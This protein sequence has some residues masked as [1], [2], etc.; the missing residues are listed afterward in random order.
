MPAV[1]AV[2]GQVGRRMA[3]VAVAWLR[4]QTLVNPD[5]RSAEGISTPT[6]LSRI[7]KFGINPEQYA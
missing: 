6:L 2:S 3:Q 5:H 4:H 7:K 1:K